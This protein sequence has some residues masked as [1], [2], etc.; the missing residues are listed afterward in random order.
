MNKLI[1]LSLSV[2]LFGCANYGKNTSEWMPEW[3]G[4]NIEDYIVA[5]AVP[6][7]VTELTD[8]RKIYVFRADWTVKDGAS[9]YC[10]F[11]F[12]TDSNG[13]I[14]SNRWEGQCA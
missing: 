1:A 3:I 2:F 14:L 6:T 13:I 11:T 5:A 12:V 8:G 4:L 9:R 7:S 10:Q